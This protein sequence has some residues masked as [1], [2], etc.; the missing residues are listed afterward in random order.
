MTEYE[1]P[2]LAGY[3]MKCDEYLSVMQ[4]ALDKGNKD[5]IRITQD[6]IYE[7]LDSAPLCV[8]TKLKQRMTALETL[9]S[10]SDL[11]AA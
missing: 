7:F 6:K 2:I 8:Q 4:S 9:C 5:E 1:S 10:Q 3:K 11:R